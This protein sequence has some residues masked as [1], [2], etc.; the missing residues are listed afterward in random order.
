MK[1]TPVLFVGH[2]SPMNAI[3]DNAFSAEWI[4]LGKRLERPKAILSVSAHW[5]IP[6]THV[7]SVPV[8]HTIYDMYGFP[9]ELYHVAYNAPGAPELAARTGALLGGKARLDDSWG[10]DHGTWSVLRRMYPEADIP[11]FQVSVDRL[12]TAAQ[13]IAIGQALSPLRDEGVMIFASGNVVHNLGRVGWDMQGGY[14]WA[15][16]FDAYVKNAVLRGDTSAVADYQ[17]VGI[18]ARQAV[19]MLDHFAPLL[20]ALGASDANDTPTVFNQALS[21]GSLSMTSY[22]WTPVQTA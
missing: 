11:V 13:H 12:A 1:R 6:G 16:E 19:P 7:S 17:Q 14:P 20:T 2:G 5:F 3:E 22:L 8:N 18:A 21:M 15:E 9:D 10:L 4:A